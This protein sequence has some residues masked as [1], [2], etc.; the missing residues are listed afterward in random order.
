MDSE[1]NQGGPRRESFFRPLTQVEKAVVFAALMIL[2][3][4]ISGFNSGGWWVR[5][6]FVI[7]AV[8]AL[9]LGPEPIGT[10]RQVSF[11][12]KLPSSSAAC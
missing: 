4:L 1:T 2:F 3:W 12:G 9:W 6:R 10:F 11:H 8:V 7:G 5:S